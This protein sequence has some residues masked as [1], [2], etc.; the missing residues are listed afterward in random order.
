[1]VVMGLCDMDNCEVYF[2]TVEPL[3]MGIEDGCCSC[4]KSTYSHFN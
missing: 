2:G 3:Y 4:D 1:M